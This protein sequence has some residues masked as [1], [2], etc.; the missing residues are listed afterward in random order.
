MA[1]LIS[2]IDSYQTAEQI[3]CQDICKGPV[4]MVRKGKNKFWFKRLV[5]PALL[6]DLRRFVE[7]GS[8]SS[9]LVDVLVKK[10]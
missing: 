6:D 8:M 4:V 1:C 10:K 5:G 2:S 3:K 9:A 7:E